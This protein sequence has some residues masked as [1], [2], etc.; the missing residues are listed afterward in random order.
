[1]TKYDIK[2]DPKYCYHA[3]SRTW[4]LVEVPGQQFIAIEGHGDPNT[5][6]HYTE[7]VEALFAVAYAIKFD[8]K[9]RLGRD[10]VVGPLEGLWWA[11]DPTVFITREKE[12]WSWRLLIAQPEWVDE[13]TI[14]KARDIA[15]SKKANPS[16]DAIHRFVLAEGLCAQLLHV[17]PYNDEGPALEA[18]HTRFV[19]D[20][21]LELTGLHHEI[22]LSDPRRT[23]PAKLRTILRQP[24]RRIST[25]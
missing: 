24:V 1:M 20:N 16:V 22:Y 10:F 18:L 25:G 12:A 21:Q 4:D 23:E 17:G 5:S 14:E 3:N 6:P 13:P 9:N 7:A 8:S 2:K 15:S 11:D 19:P